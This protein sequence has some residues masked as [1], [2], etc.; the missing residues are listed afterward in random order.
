MI[1]LPNRTQPLLI[2]LLRCTAG[3]G[4]QKEQAGCPGGIAIAAGGLYWPTQGFP[5]DHDVKHCGMDVVK[6]RDK[7]PGLQILG[8]IPKSEIQYRKRHN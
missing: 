7:Y 3:T 1:K 5:L 8:G 2:R 4:S 6:L